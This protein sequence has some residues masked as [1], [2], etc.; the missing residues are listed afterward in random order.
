[1]DACTLP[2][3]QHMDDAQRD[4]ANF[5]QA[6]DDYDT[7][8]IYVWYCNIT[9]YLNNIMFIFSSKFLVE[10]QRLSLPSPPY[11]VQVQTGDS[12]TPRSN[13]FGAVLPLSRKG[14]LRASEQAGEIVSEVKD[15]QAKASRTAEGAWNDKRKPV[16]RSIPSTTMNA[17][18]RR[19]PGRL[20]VLE[21]THDTTSSEVNSATTASPR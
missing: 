9:I 12:P 4:S 21:E 6:N 13:G 17:S 18:T 3:Q 14:V 8:T 7:S 20:V 10:I 19:P 1:M 15:R 16:P 2:K 5:I 11:Q